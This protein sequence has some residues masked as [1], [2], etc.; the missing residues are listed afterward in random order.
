VENTFTNL[1][2][3]I[4]ETVKVLGTD[5]DD[6]TKEYDDE[7][8]DASGDITLQS[9]GTK[10]W[11]RKA[12]AGLSYRYTLRPMRLE[13]ATREGSMLGSKKKIHEVVA[14]FYNSF[15]AQQGDSLT[16]LKDIRFPA[17]TTDAALYTGDIELPFDSKYS[18][19]DNIY[20]SGNGCYPCTLRALIV[21]FEKTGQ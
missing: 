12:I 16:N 13:A 19:E 20:I 10:N 17:A 7:V 8:V 9:N 18:R 11:V 2:H 15:G 14:S 21:K 5:V 1:G 6:V 3:L 4:G